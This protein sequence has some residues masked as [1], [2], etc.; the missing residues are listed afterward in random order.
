MLDSGA[1]PLAR[2]SG[3]GTLPELLEQRLGERALLETFER[4]GVPI[5]VRDA[6]STPVPLAAMMALFTRAARRLGDRTFGLEVGETMTHRAYGLWAEY[7][8]QGSTL[9]FAL[10]RMIATCPAHLSGADLELA[11]GRDHAVWRMVIPPLDAERTQ[12]ADHIL[13]PMIGFARQFLG[14]A[15]R[16]DWVEVSYERDAAAGRVEAR[17]QCPVLFGRP[18]TG[19]ALRNAELPRTRQLATRQPARTI[20]LHEVRADLILRDAPEPARALSA[21]VALR[22]LDGHSDIEGAARLAGLS[23]QGLQRRLRQKGYSYREIVDRARR[24][25][26]LGLVLESRLPLIEVALALGYED[27]ANFTRAFI[28][29]FG[30]PPSQLRRQGANGQGANGQGANGQGASGQ[31]AN[32]DLPA[33]FSPSSAWI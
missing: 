20:N 6:P 8:A 32:D 25:R 16:P 4:E 3:F 31:G 14:P 22:L 19:I 10:Q 12:H 33:P 5:A 9:G 21:I 13:P 30:H 23:M 24:S 15:W 1:I 17:L 2:A 7:G 18:G 26:A 29:W 27:Q 28:R 11:A